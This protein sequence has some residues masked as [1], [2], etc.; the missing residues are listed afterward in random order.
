MKTPTEEL[1]KILECKDEGAIADGIMDFFQ[2]HCDSLPLPGEDTALDRAMWAA[3]EYI[4]L[5][6]RDESILSQVTLRLLGEAADP[7]A[8]TVLNLRDL[9]GTGRDS[10]IRAW[11]DMLAAMAW[12]QMVPAG[13]LR[14]AGTRMVSLG[15]FQQDMD[16]TNIQVSLGWMVDHDQFRILLN[17]KNNKGEAIPD[18][19]LRVKEQENSAG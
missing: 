18:V 7:V 19:E 8:S 5:A 14:G 11:Q 3:S 2:R 10:A 13:A 9:V 17:A 16:G 6:S 15:A 1:K 4:Q 12:Q